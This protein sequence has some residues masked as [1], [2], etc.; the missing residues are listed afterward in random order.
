VAARGMWIR[1]EERG[2]RNRNQSRQ[3]SAVGHRLRDAKLLPQAADVGPWPIAV[4]LVGA[5][6][7]ASRRQSR[8]HLLI[9]SITARDP[10]RTSPLK[11]QLH[12]PQLVNCYRVPCRLRSQGEIRMSAVSTISILATLWLASFLVLLF[13]ARWLGAWIAKKSPNNIVG[14]IFCIAFAQLFVVYAAVFLVFARLP[15]LPHVNENTGGFGIAIVGVFF[16]VPAFA[17]LLLGFRRAVARNGYL[18]TAG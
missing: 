15:F 1:C 9:A 13:P 8:R 7:V 11:I 4:S 3:G 16:F 5:A 6:Q 12:R 18:Q 17:A 10:M 2:L 14:I